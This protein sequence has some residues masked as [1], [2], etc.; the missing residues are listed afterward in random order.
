[1]SLVAASTVERP[2]RNP[3]WL[4]D[5]LLFVFRKSLI[6]LSTIFSNN[7]LTVFSMHIRQHEDGSSSGLF[8]FLTYTNLAVFQL[9]GKLASVIHRLY[10]SNIN[11]V[12]RSTIVL[13]TSF[14]TTSTLGALFALSALV[15]CFSFV[16][17]IGVANSPAGNSFESLV[18][19]VGNSSSI[20]L[21]I[22]LVYL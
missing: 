20:M 11:P 14:G 19:C 17:V 13:S 9:V 7:F 10:T 21:S 6:L 4:L 5:R 1:M 12:L 22:L 15:A 18:G 16:F 2:L 8:P 3:Y